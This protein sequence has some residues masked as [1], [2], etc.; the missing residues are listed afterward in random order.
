M[1]VHSMHNIELLC[2]ANILEHRD[3][4]T[5]IKNACYEYDYNKNKI[6]AE[7]VFNILN[8]VLSAIN[9]YKITLPIKINLGTVTFLDKLTIILLECICYF[10]NKKDG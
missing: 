4:N 9:K 7:D 2:G 10:L 8:D 1:G 5:K 6:K 3:I